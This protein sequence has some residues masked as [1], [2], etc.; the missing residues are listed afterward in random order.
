M[1]KVNLET[2]YCRIKKLKIKKLIWVPLM[3]TFGSIILFIRSMLNKIFL[4][5]D[6]GP[7]EIIPL[8]VNYHF[9][10]RCNYKCGFCFHTAKTSYVLPLDVAKRGLLELAQAGMKKLNFSGGEPFIEDKGDFMGELI[11]YCKT[12]LKWAGISVSI[13]TNGSLIKESWMREYGEQVDIL[14]VSCDSFDAETNR[15]IGREQSKR[16]DHIAK[17]YQVREWCAQYKI[18]FKINTVVNTKNLNENFV[19]QI[20]ELRPVRWKVFQ[21]LLLEGEN[22]GADALRDASEFYV[23]DDQFKEFLHRHAEVSCLVPEKNDAMRNSYLILDEKMRFLNCQ[24]GKKEPSPSL[25]D[26]GVRN[27]LLGS[28]FDELEFKRRGGKYVWSKQ[29]MSDDLL[30]W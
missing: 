4:F 24:N 25:L 23:T 7:A 11:R 10:R 14:A 2:L 26:V 6:N 18:A 21:C 22:V 30:S 3:R 28:G 16:T 5:N 1:A 15:L 9:T 19:E 29:E 12:D 27:A 17:L 20:S 8:S 13:V